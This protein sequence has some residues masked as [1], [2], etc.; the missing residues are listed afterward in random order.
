MLHVYAQRYLFN[1]VR[2]II[3]PQAISP[4]QPFNAFELSVFGLWVFGLLN[5]WV[6]RLVSAYNRFSWPFNG[7]ALVSV[8]PKKVTYIGPLLDTWS[9]VG[10]HIGQWLADS[11]HAV[12]RVSVDYQPIYRSMC[13]SR[14]L[15]QYRSNVGG[16]SVTCWWYI[17]GMSVVYWSSV[18]GIFNKDPTYSKTVNI[19]IPA[20]QVNR[21][22]RAIWLANLEVNILC[23]LTCYY[24][25]LLASL[26]DQGFRL[27]EVKFCWILLFNCRSVLWRTS[28][29]NTELIFLF[30]YKI[31]SW[32]WKYYNHENTYQHS[33]LTLLGYFISFKRV[34]QEARKT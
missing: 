13:Q 19:I 18:G 24:L 4:S 33:I 28:L 2:L 11:W 32:N 20:A 1:I 10:R 12:G 29:R 27:N 25:C 23:Y 5:A 31:S 34:S 9:I 17:G 15:V 22:F 6:S 26:V 3:F 16:I 30:L 8:F 21:A 7:K 14:I